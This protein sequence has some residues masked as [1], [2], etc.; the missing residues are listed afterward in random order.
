MQRQSPRGGWGVECACTASGGN[1]QLGV[2][3]ARR[4]PMVV[5]LGVGGLLHHQVQG[6]QVSAW[7]G[8]ESSGVAAKQWSTA[9]DGRGGGRSECGLGQQRSWMCCPCTPP[10]LQPV[11]ASPIGVGRPPGAQGRRGWARLDWQRYLAILAFGCAWDVACAGAA[12]SQRATALG[13]AAA[14]LAAHS[15]P[16]P[17]AGSKLITP[18]TRYCAA[19][20]HMIQHH[21]QLSLELLLPAEGLRPDVPL[22]QSAAA[23]PARSSGAG[24]RSRKQQQ[25]LRSE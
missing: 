24:A 4:S 21:K 22:K 11:Q 19:H 9:G 10:H 2:G 7:A 12:T 23:P 8:A 20:R 15:A 1:P 6:K 3:P 13:A 17:A 5:G 16:P 14:D 18:S 25:T